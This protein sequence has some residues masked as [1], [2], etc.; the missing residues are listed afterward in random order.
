MDVDIEYE[1]I[2]VNCKEKGYSFG[3]NF[4]TIEFHGTTVLD[5]PTRY[6]NGPCLAFKYQNVPLL[7]RSLENSHQN[8]PST[9]H[10][11]FSMINAKTNPSNTISRFTY[12]Y[13]LH[14]HSD[15]PLSSSEKSPEI[16]E[17]VDIYRFPN[18]PYILLYYSFRNESAFPITEIN[19]Y[20]F[21]DFDVYGQ[22]GYKSDEAHFDPDRKIVFQ[23]DN[24][25]GDTKSIFA[26]IGS[27][28]DHPPK[29]FECNSPQKLMISLDR[30]ELRNINR[31]GPNECAVGLQWYLKYLAPGA[32]HTFPI[33][34]VFGKNRDS[35][36]KNCDTARN[37][38]E[39]RHS[40][41]ARNIH[42]EARQQI[43]PKLK[44]LAFSQAEW[45]KDD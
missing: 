26:G 41:I 28:T 20:N 5:I 8:D 25:K 27:T 19:F 38:L 1:T 31:P 30:L 39:K 10:P 15:L 3:L 9:S 14:G 23:F 44:T 6:L 21:Y 29:R 12:V 43:D 37:H 17:Y 7:I 42:T 36:F 11:I 2:C 32:V 33:M 4:K 24:M 13:E 40:D 34:L 16:Y 22:E 45:C 18:R 35:F